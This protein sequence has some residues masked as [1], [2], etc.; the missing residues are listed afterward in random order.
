MKPPRFEYFAPASLDEAVALLHRYGGEA[1]VLA[2]GQSLMPLL[3]MRLARPAALVDINRVAG[4]HSL[5]AWDGGVTIGATIRQRALQREPLITERLPILV[6]AATHIG[7]H[8]IRSRGTICG[9]LAHADPAAELPALALAFD[10][11]LVA[12]GPRGA[13]TI[14]ADG[15]YRGYLST[16]LDPSEV[17]TE[18]RIPALPSSMAWA[19]LEVSRRHGDFALVGIVAGLTIDRDRDAVAEARLVYFGVGPTPIRATEAE[20]QLIGQPPGGDAFSA[21]GEAASR[22]VDPVDDVHA[23]AAYRRSV[24]AALTRR[25]LR[26]AWERLS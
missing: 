5:E 15:F 23:T 16:A 11:E 2:G 21:A 1:K 26:Q 8:Q 13:R 18:V 3:N 7:H 12:R 4:L 24:A 14:T 19:F 10:A 9:S 22:A 6:E 25:A 17:L 20:R